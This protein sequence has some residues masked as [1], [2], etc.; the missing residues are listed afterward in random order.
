MLVTSRSM[1]ALL[2][3]NRNR[4]RC[5]N[6]RIQT[7]GVTIKNISIMKTKPIVLVLMQQQKIAHNSTAEPNRER[8]EM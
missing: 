2:F 6:Y 7:Y 3:V 1:I 8:D 4:R 5:Y